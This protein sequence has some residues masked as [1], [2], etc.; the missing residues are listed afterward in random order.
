MILAQSGDQLKTVGSQ[1]YVAKSGTTTNTTDLLRVY[2]QTI[3]TNSENTLTANDFS[4][5]G[6]KSLETSLTSSNSAI[7]LI[8]TASSGINA[9]LE[10]LD[11]M[12]KLLNEHKNN[13]L[14][15]QS[16]DKQIRQLAQE[17]DDIASSA[18]F[19]NQ[20]VL[21]SPIMKTFL[22]NQE[23]GYVRVETN[24]TNSKSLEKSYFETYQPILLYNQNEAFGTVDIYLDSI[25]F[26]SVVGDSSGEGFG[27]IVDAINAFSSTTGISAKAD[28]IYRPFISTEI[29]AGETPENFALND[30]L[31]GEVTVLDRDKDD[32]LTNAINAYTDQTGLKASKDNG[33]FVLE[34]L[35]QRGI[36]ISGDNDKLS[37]INLIDISKVPSGSTTGVAQF[38]PGDTLEEYEYE[39]PGGVNITS[40]TIDEFDGD[41]GLFDV[42]VQN[43]DNEAVQVA[44]S[45]L[46]S[47][48]NVSKVQTVDVT[49]TYGDKVLIRPEGSLGGYWRIDGLEVFGKPNTDL[50]QAG[51]LEIEKPNG[52]RVIGDRGL[53][54]F[55]RRAELVKSFGDI[56][57]LSDSDVTKA[58]VMINS[59]REK[60]QGFSAALDT[61][62]SAL[63]AHNSVTLQ[64]LS[65]SF[66]LQEQNI[67]ANEQTSIRDILVEASGFAQVQKI[68]SSIDMQ[69]LLGDPASPAGS[70]SSIPESSQSV[71]L[72][73][74]V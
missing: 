28:V 59:V 74:A 22:A 48:D 10:V 16:F 20:S 66:T 19:E 38:E 70:V 40:F 73:E 23:S 65:S 50:F 35:D 49:T 62:K 17:F 54:S 36:K 64:T 18:I 9:Q 29:A 4:K 57:L 47:G 24:E 32:A 2:S 41:F 31:I 13:P 45:V 39:L 60:L 71:L 51:K 55:N 27:A 56:S 58:E 34:S 3:S 46:S 1:A 8:D 26:N 67:A 33:V 53:N 61:Q 42:Y 52:D 21:E 68:R 12:E 44:D 69:L 43:G 6:F 14:A 37:A 63:I 7:G 30:Q 72:N 5:R 11:K 25:T 15:G